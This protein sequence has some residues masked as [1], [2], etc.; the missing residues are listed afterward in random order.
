[1]LTCHAS[2]PELERANRLAHTPKTAE[3]ITLLKDSST[4]TIA[5]S[6]APLLSALGGLPVDIWNGILANLQPRDLVRVAQLNSTFYNTV[7][8]SCPW[9]FYNTLFPTSRRIWALS[10]REA[11]DG[12]FA[13]TI[14][15]TGKEPITFNRTGNRLP[16]DRPFTT[17]FLGTNRRVIEFFG[18]S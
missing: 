8:G 1:M 15:P 6:C 17:L 3:C 12:Y 4:Q 10:W 11:I 9:R 7:T 16:Q 14:P 5:A 13:R 2:L 18:P